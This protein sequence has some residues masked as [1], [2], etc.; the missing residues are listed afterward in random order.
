[1]SSYSFEIGTDLYNMYNLEDDLSIFPP[2]QDPF[3]PARVEFEQA[4]ALVSE[5]GWGETGWRWGD[6][7]TAMRTALRAYIPGRSARLFVRLRDDNATWIY[8]DTVIIWPDEN[9]KIPTAGKIVEFILPMRI[10]ENLGASP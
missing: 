5:H 10:I 9:N 6:I 2:K 3:V 7:T 8:C 4:D 1:M